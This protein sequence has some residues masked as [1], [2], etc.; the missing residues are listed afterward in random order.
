MSVS[1]L[2]SSLYWLRSIKDVRR[3][4]K[5]I[6]S[7]LRKWSMTALNPRP[8]IRRKRIRYPTYR[9]KTMS[10]F[11]GR[12]STTSQERTPTWV[13]RNFWKR[14]PL[15]ADDTIIATSRLTT[16]QEDQRTPPWSLN[17]GSNRATYDV[18]IR[19]ESSNTTCTWS[20]TTTPI[21][22]LS[23]SSSDYR[24]RDENGPTPSI[25]R[26]CRRVTHCT[27]KACCQ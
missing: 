5:P 15:T 11:R 12:I 25:S 2:I 14:C 19:S 26:T 20:L 8:T 16:D 13:S 4:D 7:S 18:L 22:T 21:H 27:I 24:T 1:L 17:L 6:Q 3:R 10:T 23:G 9:R